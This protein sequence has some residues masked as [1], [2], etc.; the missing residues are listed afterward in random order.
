VSGE[1]KFIC[2]SD[3]GK[4]IF[5]DKGEKIVEVS[6]FNLNVNDGVDFDIE[7]VCVDCGEKRDVV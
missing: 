1:K 7:Y 3:C 2:C 6:C 4:K 5:L